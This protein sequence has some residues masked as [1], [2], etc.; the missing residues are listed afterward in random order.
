MTLQPGHELLSM[1]SPSPENGL[2]PLSQSQILLI[3]KNMLKAAADIHNDKYSILHRLFPGKEKPPT[4]K[5]LHRDIKPDNMIMDAD[6]GVKFIDYG[7]S[8]P[9][10]EKTNNHDDDTKGT[11]GYVAP[12]LITN[13]M[14]GKYNEKSEV[15]ALG[16]SLMVLA[17][18]AI[19]GPPCT[20]SGL[21]F[22]PYILNPVKTPHADPRLVALITA[23]IDA[24]PVNRPTVNEAYREINS[25]ANE[26]ARAHPEGPL[27]LVPYAVSMQDVLKIYNP[28]D[29]RELDAFVEKIKESGVNSI[30]FMSRDMPIP[31]EILIA[32]RR[33]FQKAGMIHILPNIYYGT[34]VA[35]LDAIEKYYCVKF[36]TESSSVFHKDMPAGVRA[37]R[38]II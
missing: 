17:D 5:L 21:T 1:V 3:S 31:D 29:I 8:V 6:L 32:A 30:A 12:E 27:G 33:A 16:V 22:T 38:L 37:N 24:D 11:Y 13:E 7:F 19:E 18:L 9:I 10:N 20:I 14:I 23:M 2:I 36:G 35:A 15:Y 25:I 34:N 4:S 26:A 28:N